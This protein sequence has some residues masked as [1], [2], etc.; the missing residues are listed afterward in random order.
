[1]SRRRRKREAKVAVRR[2]QRDFGLITELDRL[3]LSDVLRDRTPS[4]LDSPV[5]DRRRFDFDKR[6]VRMHDGRPARLE[7]S[8][9]R[10]EVAKDNLNDRIKFANPTSVTV[11]TRR[12]ARREALFAQ[13]KVGRGKRVSGKRR[14]TELSKIVCRGR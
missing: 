6:T 5:N 9:P 10:S 11:C 7:L 3:L 12:F 2:K 8:R 14:L 4:V 13:G 1:M